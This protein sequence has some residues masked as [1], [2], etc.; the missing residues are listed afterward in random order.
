MGWWFGPIAIPRLKGAGPARLSAERSLALRFVRGG[1]MLWLGEKGRVVETCDGMPGVGVV[2]EGLVVAA[3][4]KASEDWTGE[5]V[6]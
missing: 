3:G 4:W 5:A 2:A 1:E 6:T